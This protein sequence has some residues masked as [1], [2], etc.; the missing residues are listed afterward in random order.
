MSYFKILG[1][2][3]EPFSTSPDP[4]F[5]FESREHEKALTNLMIELRL[6]R[7]LNVILGDVGTGKT[8]LSRKLY[9]MIKSQD[10][11]I[12]H[13]MLDPVYESDEIFLTSLV[14]NFDVLINNDGPRILELKEALERF[15]FQKGVEE[16]KTV[17][18]II[19][20]AQKLNEVT[21][22]CLRVMLNYETNEFKLLQLV[23]LGQME[24]HSKVIDIPNFVDRINFKYTLNPLDEEETSQMIDFRIKQAGY[25]AHM[26]LFLETAI[27]EIYR[28]THGYPRR[29]NM[30]CHKALKRLVMNNKFVVDEVMIRAIINEEVKQGWQRAPQPTIIN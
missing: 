13:M 4:A 27:K 23:L 12:C 25:K 15:L 17:V 30:I 28:Y 26:H 16:N 19:D 21:L 8:T 22:E 10:R 29:V 2:D 6:K 14:R 9:Q 5:F 3:K 1:F 11:F 7:G 18:L 20:E 24:L